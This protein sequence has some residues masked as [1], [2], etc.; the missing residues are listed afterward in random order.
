MYGDDLNMLLRAVPIDVDDVEKE[1]VRELVKIEGRW[2]VKA[3]ANN[4][5]DNW[6]QTKVNQDNFPSKHEESKMTIVN[7]RPCKIQCLFAADVL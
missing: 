6:Y 1:G 3:D 7:M 5:G 2:G 4:A